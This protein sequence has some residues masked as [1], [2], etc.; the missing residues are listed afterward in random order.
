M[1]YLARIIR[2]E[3]P[4][5]CA[6]LP[7]DVV[8]GMNGTHVTFRRRSL[9]AWRHKNGKGASAVSDSPASA[10]ASAKVL[11]EKV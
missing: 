2:G 7:E 9:R 1:M 6:V 11:L 8:I 10:I 5:V 3:R 4:F